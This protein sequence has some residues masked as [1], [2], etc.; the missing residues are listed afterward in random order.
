MRQIFDYDPKPKL[1]NHQWKSLTLSRPTK[2]RQ[3]QTSKSSWSRSSMRW[4]SS[5][6]SSCHRVR[7]LISKSTRRSCGV[8]FA[9]WARRDESGGQTDHNAQ[10]IQQL[11]AERNIAVLDQPPYLPDLTPCD[12]FLFPKTKGIVKVGRPSRRP[13]RRSWGASQKKPFRSVAEKYEKMH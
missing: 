1:Q 3:S 4:T 13:Y 12:I 2:V 9:Q 5:E 10:S 11:L 8:C 6:A 7:G